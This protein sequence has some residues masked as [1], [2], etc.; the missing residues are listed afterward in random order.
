MGAGQEACQRSAALAEQVGRPEIY[1]R[2]ALAF[3]AELVPGRVDQRLVGLLE[4]ALL[5]QQQQEQQHG[6]PSN[7]ELRPLL[8]ARLAA[9]LMPAPSSARALALAR[10][11][12]DEARRLGSPNQHLLAQV[13]STARAAMTPADDLDERAT[14]DR[15]LAALAAGQGDRLLEVQ[16]RGRLVL[17]G[18]EEGDSDAVRRELATQQRLAAEIRVPR[19]LLRAASMRLLWSTVAGNEDDAARAEAEVR[20][21]A[22]GSGETSGLAIIEANRFT[23]AELSGDVT[24]A[25]AALQ[26]LKARLASE[27]SAAIWL[28]FLCAVELTKQ[29]DDAGVRAQLAK[30]GPVGARPGATEQLGA[31]APFMLVILSGI[32]A[33]L[34]DPEWMEAIYAQLLPFAGR[35]AVNTSLVASLGPVDHHLARLAAELGRRENAAAH[36]RKAIALSMRA[37][38]PAFEAQSRRALAALEVEPPASAPPSSSVSSPPPPP[39]LQRQGDLWTLKHDGR[40]ARLKDSKGLHYLAALLREPGREFHA[41]DL[42]GVTSAGAVEGEGPRPAGDAGVWLDDRAKAEYRHRLDQLKSLSEDSEER[43]DREGAARF[44]HERETLARE[45]ARA[46]GLGG[47]DRR[48]S[49]ASERARI[50]VQRRLRDV[51]ERVAELDASMA[52]HLDMH[53]K[54]G[55]FCSWQA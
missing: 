32:F 20:A 37:G 39:E 25:T 33:G 16:A 48:A 17:D 43:G 44:A 47:R 49:S 15:E 42:V 11:A 6:R 24:G 12:I 53:I 13:I 30:L 19:Q 10:A 55:I 54:T 14:L 18:I 21:L 38:F 26:G 2:A 4:S 34:R 50:N 28:P 23:R 35:N 8:M 29:G 31:L 22:D 5:Q 46:V 41:G 45:L 9:A 1:A 52:R 51:I 36:L 27:P 7:E 40:E 3:G